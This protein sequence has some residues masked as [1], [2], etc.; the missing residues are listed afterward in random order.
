MKMRISGNMVIVA[1][2]MIMQYDIYNMFG[3]WHSMN[4]M[5]YYHLCPVILIIGVLINEIRKPIGK[6]FK[7]LSY[8]LI[9]IS[10]YHFLRICYDYNPDYFA[11]INEWSKAKAVYYFPIFFSILVLILIILTIFKKK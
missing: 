6:L 5:I 8:G 1:I 10:L 7:V 11:F 9:F 4:W 2:F 3:S